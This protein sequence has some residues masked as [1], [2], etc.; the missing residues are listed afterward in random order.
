MNTRSCAH[1]YA[2]MQALVDR[3]YLKKGE[4]SLKVDNGVSIS[5]TTIGSIPL[6]LA[7]GLIINLNFIY[8]VP[9]IYKNIIS[10][11]YLDKYGYVF[12]ISN[13]CMSILK[14]EIFYTNVN[15]SDDLYL[16]EVNNKYI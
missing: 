4:I 6:Y 9:S 2:N 14:D 12:I 15:I 8:Y 11:S 16:L 13:L 7:S 1:I 3:K 10:V 5:A